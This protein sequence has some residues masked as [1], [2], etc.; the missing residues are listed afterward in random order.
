MQM[1]RSDDWLEPTRERIQQWAAWLRLIKVGA[2]HSVCGY[3][4]RTP[5]EA[6]AASD[7]VLETEIAMAGLK[8]ENELVYAVLFIRYYH[9]ESIEE[10]CQRM[11]E[12]HKLKMGCSTFKKWVAVGEAHI[13]GCLRKKTETRESWN[14]FEKSA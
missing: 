13:H 12:Q 6:E 9:D 10:S 8:R 5:K 11:L 3:T 4:E 7:E 2:G 1:Q 14:Y